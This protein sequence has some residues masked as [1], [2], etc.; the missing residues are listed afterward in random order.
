[1]YID[2]ERAKKDRPTS[3]VYDTVVA[4]DGR[5]VNINTTRLRCFFISLARHWLT[6]V[7]LASNLLFFAYYNKAGMHRHY[8]AGILALGLLLYYLRLHTRN[9]IHVFHNRMSKQCASVNYFSIGGYCRFPTGLSVENS[10]KEN[11]V[12]HSVSITY[13]Y[14]ATVEGFFLGATMLLATV[15]QH[16]LTN[17][18]ASSAMIKALVA[19]YFFSMGT[20]AAENIAI[21]TVPVYMGN[22][23][24]GGFVT[25]LRSIYDT[26]VINYIYVVYGVAASVAEGA[27]Q[28]HSKKRRYIVLNIV[29]RVSSTLNVVSGFGGALGLL[30][31][32][33]TALPRW[34]SLGVYGAIVLINALV[35]TAIY[36]NLAIHKNQHD[37][38]EA[39]IVDPYRQTYMS[40]N[41]LEQD[42]QNGTMMLAGSNPRSPRVND[43]RTAASDRLPRSTR[44]MRRFAKYSERT[45]HRPRYAIV[46]VVAQLLLA[47]ANVT[48]AAF[49]ENSYKG[50]DVFLVASSL[51]MGY[52]YYVAD[53]V[54]TPN[55]M[56]LVLP[57]FPY[58]N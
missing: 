28:I 31:V 50:N 44:L 7:F 43:G 14:L 37:T 45:K 49:M 4:P 56:L 12:D 24:K 6:W 17:G 41:I 26:H 55:S 40:A 38:L 2:P 9:L 3:M 23:P 22:I 16:L 32:Y 13:E 25:Y 21:S 15:L 46:G 42:E 35:Q 34:Y 58:L 20:L 39:N 1:M 30:Y 18:T 52:L 36:T 19:A 48:L 29:A 53:I 33:N 10:E 57:Y 11:V 8:L 5:S 47:A 51:G 27:W 54:D